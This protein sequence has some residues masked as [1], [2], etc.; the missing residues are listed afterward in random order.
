MNVVLVLISSRSVYWW[1]A[2]PV[3]ADYRC[4][5]QSSRSLSLRSVFFNN[6]LATFLQSRDN[7]LHCGRSFSFAL[8]F[9]SL[10]KTGWIPSCLW[11]NNLAGYSSLKDDRE[12]R[13]I[14]LHVCVEPFST[15]HLLNLCNM[16]CFS[17]W[18]SLFLY[19]CTLQ[20]V[21]LVPTAVVP[22]TKL[23]PSHLWWL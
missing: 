22:S 20:D 13:L 6:K 16:Y 9:F 18:S 5:P 17:V 7:V 11:L 4:E 14:C 2:L 3:C 8:G 21:C 12:S 15:G 1:L 23:D 10:W 19:T